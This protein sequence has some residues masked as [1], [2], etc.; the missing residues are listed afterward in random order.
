MLKLHLLTGSIFRLLIPV[1]IMGISSLPKCIPCNK[2]FTT[3][4]LL[5]EHQ[6]K[7]LKL[8]AEKKAPKQQKPQVQARK[9]AQCP[10]CHVE[11]RFISHLKRHIQS[12]H[13]D[14]SRPFACEVCGR[15]FSSDRLLK[16]HKGVHLPDELKYACKECDKK[17]AT[18]WS[19]RMHVNSF[20]RGVTYECDVC[21]KKFTQMSSLKPHKLKHQT[22]GVNP[23]KKPQKEGILV[24]WICGKTLKT[25]RILDNHMNSHLKINPCVCEICRKGFTNSKKLKRHMVVHTKEK[26]YKCTECDKCFTQNAPL[27]IHIR[28]VHRKETPHECPV[29]LKKFV[30]QALLNTH[31]KFH[32]GPKSKK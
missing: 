19:C 16:R 26:P 17:F 23:V 7:C 6:S 20:H 22:E 12:A 2:Y 15:K 21:N 3:R 9:P 28:R 13:S 5:E 29:C 11:V 32:Q 10:L 4:R 8:K 31:M 25:K 24:C 14:V 18:K 1:R 30:L 27:S